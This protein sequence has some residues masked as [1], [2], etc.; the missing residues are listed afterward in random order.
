M[1]GLH[2]RLDV[3]LIKTPPSLTESCFRISL[4]KN[5]AIDT[6]T[7]KA[8]AA[9][10]TAGITPGV[11][12][13]EP[14]APPTEGSKDSSQTDLSRDSSDINLGTLKLADRTTAYHISRGPITDAVTNFFSVKGKG[15]DTSALD[16]IATQPSVYDGP[17]ASH[18]QPRADWENIEAFDPSFR[19][20]WREEKRALR[21]VDW[22]VLSWVCVMFFALG[23]LH[24]SRLVMLRGDVDTADV[25][26][27]RGRGVHTFTI[28]R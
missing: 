2:A 19:W 27:G 22:K 23:E 8:Q 1:H 26:L 9:G 28:G 12:S 15:K 20:T 3:Q 21:K 7:A 14:K 13:I 5:M 18:Y 17:H 6:A 4:A 25:C 24:C 11:G 16:D 10:I